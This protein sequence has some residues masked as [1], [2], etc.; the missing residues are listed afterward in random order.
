MQR[1]WRSACMHACKAYTVVMLKRP[2]SHH[3]DI[4]II[5]PRRTA[6]PSAER[7][8]DGLGERSMRPRPFGKGMLKQ[9][10]SIRFVEDRG[11]PWCKRA[12]LASRPPLTAC[13]VFIRDC[14]CVLHS[15]LVC[16]QMIDRSSTSTRRHAG[17]WASTTA[18]ASSAGIA[19][20]RTSRA[21]SSDG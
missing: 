11:K 9:R 2:R 21:S 16:R 20:S 4:D 14:T 5:P 15:S 19:S 6:G 7:P 3:I 18:R 17:T 10:V 8:P 1:E 12:V 13:L